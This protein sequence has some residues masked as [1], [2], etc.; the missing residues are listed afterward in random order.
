LGDDHEG[1]RTRLDRRSL[2]VSAFLRSA[3]SS[4]GVSARPMSKRQDSQP[5]APVF[6]AAGRYAVQVEQVSRIALATL[7]R[8]TATVN[9]AVRDDLRGRNDVARGP[10]GTG[11]GKMPSLIY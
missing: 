5:V 10:S 4:A 6:Q 8:G 1:T 11:L 3:S 9:A 7:A 2:A